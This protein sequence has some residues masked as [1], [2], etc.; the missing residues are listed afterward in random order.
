MDMS[1]ISRLSTGHI[2]RVRVEEFVI[3]RVKRNLISLALDYS[4]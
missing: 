4:Q 1:L 2:S 3:M